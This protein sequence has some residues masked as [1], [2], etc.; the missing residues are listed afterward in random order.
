M[1]AACMMVAVVVFARQRAGPPAELEDD[2]NIN[3]EYFEKH[4]FDQEPRGF[5]WEKRRLDASEYYDP[6]T[7][8]WAKEKG[9]PKPERWAA[10][11][12]ASEMATVNGYRTTPDSG[13]PYHWIE[14][15]NYSRI[16][17]KEAHAQRESWGHDPWGGPKPQIAGSFKQRALELDKGWNDGEHLHLTHH[18][19]KAIIVR[20]RARACACS[21]PSFRTIVHAREQLITESPLTSLTWPAVAADSP[22]QEPALTPGGLPVPPSLEPYAKSP[23]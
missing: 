4:D 15:G 8:G 2:A 13:D 7:T 14:S 11:G 5:P 10:V 1:C 23:K 20:P 9:A 17:T 22:V 18:H 21:E 3:G 12:E 6:D 16:L 19:G